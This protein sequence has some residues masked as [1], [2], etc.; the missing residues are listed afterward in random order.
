MNKEIDKFLNS[1][2]KCLRCGEGPISFSLNY[3]YNNNLVSKY[4]EFCSVGC[5]IDSYNSPY[6]ENDHINDYK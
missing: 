5:Y 1:K 6:F 4:G 3:D 2:I